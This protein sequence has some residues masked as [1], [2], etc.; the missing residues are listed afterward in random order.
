MSNL[1]DLLATA[2]KLRAPGGCPW[3]AEQTHESLVQYLIEETYELVDAIESGNRDEILEELG[4][5]QLDRLVSK[6]SFPVEHSLHLCRQLHGESN[7]RLHN[8]IQ[9][10]WIQLIHL[11]PHNK[12][13]S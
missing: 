4:V 3:D 11:I 6:S 9:P 7:L 12:C 5:S 1:D 13:H 8:L 2:H 10:Q